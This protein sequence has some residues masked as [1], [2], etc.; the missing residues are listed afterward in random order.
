MGANAQTSVP[1]FTA[2][3]VLTAAQQNQINTGIPVFA[4]TT[5]RDAAFGGTGEKDLAEGQF[6]YL[7][8]TD[9]TQYYN[10]SAW[11]KA[12][13]AGLTFLTKAAFSGVTSVSLPNGTFTAAYENYRFFLTLTAL[14][15]DSNFTIRM[16]AAGGDNSASDYITSFGGPA[17][18][19]TFIYQVNN[20]GTAFVVGNADATTL[21]YTIV[22]DIIRPQTT[23]NPKF[24]Q[25]Q[26]TY[27]ND[28]VAYQ[29]TLNGGGT[30]GNAT[31]YDSISFISST[32]NSMTG[33]YSVYGYNEV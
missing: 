9:E 28:A 32:N 12:G 26:V 22:L 5:T 4:S 21:R 10:G 3:Q 1:E 23:T 8:S 31:Q 30:C 6:C 27:I 16:R 29:V 24:I 15:A 19:S 18:N 33:R 20:T 11:V 2:G 13:P 14:T 17:T 7:E 25:G